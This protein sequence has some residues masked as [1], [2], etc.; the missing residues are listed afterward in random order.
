MPTWSKNML[1]KNNR[2]LA[3]DP[4]A[5]EMG[6][7]VLDDAQLIHYGVKSLKTYRPQQILKRSVADILTRLI[8]EYSITTLIIEDGHFSQMAS[9]LY[10]AVLHAIQETANYRKLKLAVYGS[11]TIRKFLCRDAKAT[12]QRTAQILAERYPEL[13]MYLEQN[14]RWKDKYWMHVF[15]ALAA[16]SIH[17][18]KLKE[19]G[20]K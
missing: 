15:D 1:T 12:K 18:M 3:I 16:G 7:A 14:R 8:I 4:G 9:P 10:N 17:V 6:I 5:R 13:K 20:R 2:L 19:E 11:K